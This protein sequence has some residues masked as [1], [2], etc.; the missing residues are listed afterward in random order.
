MAQELL[1][2]RPPGGQRPVTSQG[3]A[4]HA[5]GSSTAYKTTARHCVRQLRCMDSIS[6]INAPDVR[7]LCLFP[8]QWHVWRRCTPMLWPHTDPQE[9]FLQVSKSTQELCDGS[10]WQDRS[11]EHARAVVLRHRRSSEAVAPITR[12]L[13]RS[14]TMRRGHVQGNCACGW[15]LDFQAANDH[16]HRAVVFPL[17]L[18][19]AGASSCQEYRRSE[20]SPFVADLSRVVIIA[21]QYINHRSRAMPWHYQLGP[22]VSVI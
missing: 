16:S 15:Y 21:R 8:A 22:C 12:P 13:S 14:F 7:V 17:G 3:F 20:P 9:D 5:S 11:K 1:L 6:S 19:P 10:D 4:I 18:V 2:S